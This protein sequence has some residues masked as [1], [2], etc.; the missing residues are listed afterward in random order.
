MDKKGTH[1]I[2]SMLDVMTMEEEEEIMANDIKGH[3]FEMASV[4]TQCL[5]TLGS[6]SDTRCA[7]IIVEFCGTKEEIHHR[8][9]IGQI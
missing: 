7:E 8:R 6:T 1:T 9:S 3:I 5:I 2:Q 4:F